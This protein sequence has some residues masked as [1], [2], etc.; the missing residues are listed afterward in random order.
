[1]ED[2]ASTLRK[3]LAGGEVNVGKLER[4]ASMFGGGLLTGAGIRR[5]GV[6]GAVL[7]VAGAMLLHRG[8]T[9]HCAVYAAL[10]VDTSGDAAPAGTTGAAGAPGAT[11]TESG[12]GRVRVEGSIIVNRMAEELYAY[13]RDFSH[14]PSYMDRIISVRVLD[15][16]RSHWTAEGPRGRTWEWTTE[17]T[18]DVPGRRI[19]WHTTEDSDLPHGGSVEFTPGRLGET[20]VRFALHFHPPGGVVGQAIASAFHQVP[21]KMIQE[22]LRRFKTL[23][24][25]GMTAD[26][27]GPAH[28]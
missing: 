15:E 7:G 22:D 23:M 19:V 3:A 17:V 21:E 28:A 9:G 24:E 11:R 4:F 25:A 1:M 2:T 10:G 14:A 6:G 27:G 12:G 16:R 18:E 5:G 20:T 8:A 13:W 26:S